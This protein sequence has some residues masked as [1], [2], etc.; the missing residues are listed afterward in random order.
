METFSKHFLAAVPKMRQEILAAFRGQEAK[1]GFR[2]VWEHFEEII[3]PILI[4]CLR[5]P[6]FSVPTS[7]IKEATSKSAYPDL[8]IR[9]QG[10]VF[11]IDVKSGEDHMDPWYDIS[12]LDTYEEKHLDKYAGEFSVVVRW[13]GREKM[14][15]VDVYIEATYQ[16]VGYR[17]A[18]DGVSY[19]PYDGKLRPKPWS[20]FEKGA[21]FW[22]DLE[23]F[24]AGL[25]A[26]RNFRRKSYIL[27]WYEKMN[28]AQRSGLRQDLTRID[29]GKPVEFDRDL[30]K[31]E[32]DQLPG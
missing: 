21:S 31:A 24:K 7:D 26:S 3:N 28:P 2:S 10:N 5:Q 6:P 14:E 20:H 1:G 9:F 8:K 15:V 27:E 23:H 25:A 13:R 18:S 12:R 11:A 16:T 22:R 4:A 19:R 30:P 17:A 32:G 29:S